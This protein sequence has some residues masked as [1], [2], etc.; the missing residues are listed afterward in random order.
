MKIAGNLLHGILIGND[1]H[2]GDIDKSTLVKLSAVGTSDGYLDRLPMLRATVSKAAA[3]SA[4]SSG[5]PSCE[6]AVTIEVIS[7][8]PKRI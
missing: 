2:S 6:M 8:V 4:L 5:M 3:S 7:G 1:R